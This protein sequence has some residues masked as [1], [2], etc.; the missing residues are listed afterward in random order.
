M[1]PWSSLGLFNTLA[2][3]IAFDLGSFCSS[4]FSQLQLSSFPQLWREKRHFGCHGWSMSG[5]H[6]DEQSIGEDWWHCLSKLVVVDDEWMGTF[7]EFEVDQMD[8]HLYHCSLILFIMYFIPLI[9]SITR[10]F[11]DKI[12]RFK[13]KHYH[14]V[15]IS[16][17]CF[18]IKREFWESFFSFYLDHRWYCGCSYYHPRIIHLLCSCSLGNSFLMF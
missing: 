10:E 16:T 14:L 18:L 5:K 17:S 15:L 12:S 11:L 2:S 8:E 4:F 6:K 3:S 7:I 1:S 13:D 9:S